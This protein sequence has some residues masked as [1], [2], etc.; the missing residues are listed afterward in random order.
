MDVLLP[1]CR[2]IDR[3]VYEYKFSGRVVYSISYLLGWLD[4]GAR[5]FTG[6]HKHARAV[7]VLNKFGEEK[8]KEYYLFS[9]V[10]NPYDRLVS[11]Y[12]YIRQSRTHKNNQD[13]SNMS[14]SEFIDW[15]INQEPVKQI[16]YLIEPSTGALLVDFIGKYENLAED[17]KIIQNQTRING[18]T[19]KH[20]KKSISR[21]SAELRDYYDD[22][23]A[24]KV[25]KY[26]SDD[27]DLL[28][29]QD[30]LK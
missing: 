30:I 6:F 8:I 15:Y 24:E 27:F 21:R 19:L 12:Y 16:D 23:S 4:D 20:K 17:L 3:L 2:L 14:F 9:F 25:S 28:G 22:E 1:S 13:L 18:G 11:L 29:Y 5:Q 10:R 26:F 7:D